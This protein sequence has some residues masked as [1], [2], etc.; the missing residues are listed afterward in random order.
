MINKMDV[1]AKDIFHSYFTC[2]IFKNLYEIILPLFVVGKVCVNSFGLTYSS[3]IS[4]DREINYF[5]SLIDSQ[6]I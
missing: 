1:A 4:R 2:H 3:A 6:T 5:L